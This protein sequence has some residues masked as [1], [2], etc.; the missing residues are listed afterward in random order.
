MSPGLLFLIASAYLLLLF[1]I[2]FGGDR[3]AARKRYARKPWAWSLALA[4]YCTSW[5]Y[6]GAVGQAAESSWSYLP[7]YLGPVL[8]FIF[9]HRLLARMIDL[10]K[11]NSLTSLP[12]FVAARYGKDQRIAVLC[13]AL[14][15]V[16]V[17][18]Y[19][20]L[21]LKGIAVSF[22]VLAPPQ[23]AQAPDVALLSAA[24]LGVFAILFGTRHISSNESHHGLLVAV[25]FESVVKLVAFLCVAWVVLTGPLTQ[26]RDVVAEAVMPV[27]GSLNLSFAVQTV[28]AALAILCLPRQFHM[29]VVENAHRDDLKVARWV[30][31]LYFVLISVPVV[32]LAQLGLETLGSGVNP[33]TFMLRL[34]LATGEQ[35]L[36]VFAFLGGF[37]AATAMVVVS[38]IA[39][40]T[41]VCNEVVMPWL[42]H[43]GYLHSQQDWGSVVKRVRRLTIGVLLASAYLVYLFI[44]PDASLASLGLIAFVG[45][46]QL[47][48]ALIGAMYWR[49][50]NARGALW[51][52]SGGSLI[53]AYTLLI[54]A[55]FSGQDWLLSG[56]F[57]WSWLSPYGLF[58]L[59]GLDPVSHASLFSLGLNL[60]L[61]IGISLGSQASLQERLDAARFL[62][63]L[64]RTG[65]GP[66]RVGDLSA[67]LERFFGQERSHSLLKEFAEARHDPL[68]DDDDDAPPELVSHVERLLASTMGGATARALLS[69]VLGGQFEPSDETVQ[70]LDRSS[71]IVRFNREL[72]QATLD[73]LTQ[74]V[75]VVDADQRLVGWNQRYQ[76]IFQLPDELL[77]IGEP[78]ES[79]LRYNAGHALV[80]PE[81]D[82]EEWIQRRLGHLRAK[83]AYRTER[84][85]PDGRTLEIR[86][87]PM[88]GG[89]FVSTF[90]DISEFKRI[91]DNLAKTNLELEERVAFRTRELQLARAEA[92][93]ANSSKTRFLAAASHDLMQP[94]NAARLFASAVAP[95][96]N[97]PDSAGLLRGIE[98]SLASMEDL[99]GSLLDISKLDAGV[100]PMAI[101]AFPVQDILTGLELQFGVLARER[102]LTLTMHPSR[103]WV[104]SDPALVKRILQNLLSNALRYT[105]NGRVVLGLRRVGRD[106]VRIEVLD[107]GPGIAEA[108]RG[109][110]FQEF[111][112]LTSQDAQGER[113]FGLGLAICRRIADLLGARLELRSQ[114]GRGS[115]FTLELPRVAPGQQIPVPAAA[116]KVLGSLEGVRVLCIDNDAPVLQAMQA[117]LQSWGCQVSLASHEA[118]ALEAWARAPHD[119]VIADFHLDDGRTGVDALNALALSVG[120]AIPGLIVTADH[121]GEAD[122]AADAA[123]YRVL[124]KPVKPAALRAMI[125]RLTLGA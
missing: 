2:A 72:L 113:G 91:Q 95:Q 26:A 17:L 119:L 106:A 44:A 99:L 86:G 87:E 68:P 101:K 73:N 18:P 38:S 105:S 112:R 117:L 63:P 69:S 92:E 31:P 96:V 59:Q 114:P 49:H 85:L 39:L 12:D 78:V 84:R 93:A 108:D 83:T 22:G 65:H 56:P 43:R 19:I 9:G 41:M 120:D 15:V 98:Q 100:L 64:H 28:I 27:A 11:R 34:P 30:F 37:S 55:F 103:V 40:S 45:I 121:G 20:A 109:R 35:G 13:T 88:P 10:A 16:A 47:A 32:P 77:R 48:P 66:V 125:S 74:G 57:G 80:E 90:T 70:A 24:G 60:L 62:E 71:D 21:Q 29:T 104:R 51:G 124:K 54:P 6:Y 14:S 53:W 67:V 110:V 23:L 107:T 82:A 61:F 5:T 58:G 75:S 76:D 50:G 4:V 116:R 46:A 1:V 97:M 81:Q 94:L 111:Q 123:G 25:A 115:A 8:V 122:A 36:A 102:G 79:I 7:I 3:R 89:G 52:L 33:D 118:A 42:L